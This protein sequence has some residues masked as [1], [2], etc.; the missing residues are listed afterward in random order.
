MQ[1]KKA[2]IDEV[3]KKLTNETF[4]NTH[5]ANPRDFTRDR[6]LTFV[7][8]FMLILRKSLKS[9]QLALNELFIH[10]YIDR[11]TS[12]SAYTQARKKLLHTAFIELN[13][14]IIRIYY[15][16]DKI[17][18]W[19]GYRCFG[20]DGSKIILPNF[21]DIE[22]EYG[23]IKLKNQY[24]EDKYCCAIF[25]CC[26]D[27]LNNIAMKSTLNAG[28]SY[29]VDLAKSMLLA[30]EEKDLLIY[31]RGYASYE[32]LSTLVKQNKNYIIRCSTRSFSAANS[33]FSGEGDW[34]KIVYL[35]PP[36]DQRK[37][38][39]DKGLPAEI[40]V[41]FIS[42]VLPTGEIEVLMTSLFDST[43]ER[44]EFKY[45][46]G[47]RW[48][49]ESFYYLLKSRLSL[50]NFTGQ[51]AES[52]KQ[53][54]WSTIFISNCET[55]MTEEVESKMNT[56]LK[57]G[58]YKKKINKAV[59]FNTIKNMAFE[60]FYNEPDSNRAIEKMTLLFQ[61]NTVVKRPE[62]VNFRKKTS[63]RRSYNFLKRIKKVVF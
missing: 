38:I 22:K 20:I 2:G 51:T 31:D 42:V 4:I 9:L 23:K 33:L 26:Y 47:L 50:E 45:L 5:K 29:E 56:T 32:F 30:T 25:E 16:D 17:K 46:Y 61:T 15:S 48:G 14:D 8:V 57:D 58:Q 3:N 41:R 44:D 54:F 28:V 7:V 18:R 6:I 1:K 19:K 53:D 60:I 62:R 11:I 49:V 10:G 34:S 52:I 59:S 24:I 43:I 40:K 21:S 12:S 39:Q 37:N 63:I 55:L 35:K 36:K 13:E 27:V